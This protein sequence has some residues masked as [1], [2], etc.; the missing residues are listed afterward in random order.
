[1]LN[2]GRPHLRCTQINKLHF[3][4]HN[5]VIEDHIL[6]WHSCQICY[7]L[8]IKVLLLFWLSRSMYFGPINFFLKSVIDDENSNISLPSRLMTRPTKWHVRP[9]KNQ[10]S[11]GSRPFWSESSLSAWRKLTQWAHSEDSDQTGEMPRLIWVFAGR[12]CH[13]V[14]FVMK[15]INY[16]NAYFR[17]FLFS[18]EE[19]DPRKTARKDVEIVGRNFILSDKKEH[20]CEKNL[21]WT[22]HN[23]DRNFIRGSGWGLLTTD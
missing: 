7:P 4:R 14:G 23:L 19:I 9:A 5:L 3:R 10:I 21:Q 17:G 6:D 12:T 1:M 16:L 15:R 11:L 22:E 8:E 18:D 20:P 13:F 2:V